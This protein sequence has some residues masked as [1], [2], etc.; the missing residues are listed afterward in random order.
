MKNNQK[1]L[2]PLDIQLFAEDGVETP[3]ATPVKM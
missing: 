2:L 3:V 1:K